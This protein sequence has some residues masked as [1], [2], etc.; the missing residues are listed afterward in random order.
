MR[1]RN[2]RGKAKAEG[3]ISWSLSLYVIIKKGI[4]PNYGDTIVYIYM[5][6]YIYIYIHIY[7]YIYTYIYIYIYTHINIYIYITL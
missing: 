5:A 7:I 3:L 1:R 4:S 2:A 6:P